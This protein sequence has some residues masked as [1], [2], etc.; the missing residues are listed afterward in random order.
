MKQNFPQGADFYLDCQ[1]IFRLDATQIFII[2]F[3]KIAVGIY[4]HPACSVYH[5]HNLVPFV[6]TSYY[7]LIYDSV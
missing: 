3:A 6:S 1:Y 5:R 2:L 4:H 7:T